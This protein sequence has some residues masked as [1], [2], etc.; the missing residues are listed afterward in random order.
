MNL[1]KKLFSFLKSKKE[2]YILNVIDEEFIKTKKFGLDIT[3]K[4]IDYEKSIIV[5]T[6]LEFWDDIQNANNREY[7]I[8]G[9]VIRDSI[10]SRLEEQTKYY[11]NISKDKLVKN[12][13]NCHLTSVIDRLFMEINNNTIRL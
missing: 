11:F 6:I 10:F 9:K 4:D 2:N 12:M 7:N 1:H 8:I 3:K 5:P 13:Y